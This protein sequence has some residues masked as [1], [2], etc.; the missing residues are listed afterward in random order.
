LQ[1]QHQQQQ[2]RQQQ[3]QQE[4]ALQPEVVVIDLDGEDDVL[5][6]AETQIDGD[7]EGDVLGCAQTQID[8]DDDVV[9]ERDET[10]IDDDYCTGQNL[11]APIAPLPPRDLSCRKS[12]ENELW[13]RRALQRQMQRQLQFDFERDFAYEQFQ[14]IY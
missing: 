11:V 5:G 1:Q 2:Q 7:D 3:Q 12:I 8:G 6:C 4:P 14:R 9:L 10:Q 13:L